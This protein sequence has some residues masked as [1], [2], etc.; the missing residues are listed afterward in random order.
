MKEE[1]YEL[2]EE[3]TKSRLFNNDLAPTTINERTWN[4]YNYTALW[5]GMAHCIPMLFKFDTLS[6]SEYTQPIKTFRLKYVF[7]VAKIIKTARYVIMKLSEN[8]HYKDVYEKC[9]A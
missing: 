2:K 3:I 1:M 7:L 9:L 4:T 6:V 5:I 8:Y